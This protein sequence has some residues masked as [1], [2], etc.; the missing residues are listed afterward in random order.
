MPY[1]NKG[2]RCNLDPKIRT[3]SKSIH[4]NP[5]ALNYAISRLVYL[6]LPSDAG[7]AEMSAARAVLHD[8]ADEFYR[9]V[10]VPYEDGKCALNGEVYSQ[11][12]VHSRPPN[13]IPADR[14]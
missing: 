3:L 13:P 2:L 12:K 4:N 5:G 1:I 8:A 6:F 10:M 11:D 14:L 9:K 7:Y